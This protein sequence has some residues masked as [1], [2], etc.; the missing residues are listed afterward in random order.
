L[1]GVVGRLI[2]QRGVQGRYSVNVIAL[3]IGLADDLLTGG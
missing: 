2:K 3:L 1:A